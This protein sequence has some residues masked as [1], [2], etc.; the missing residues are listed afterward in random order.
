M[1]RKNHTHKYQL[2]ATG[3]QSVWACALPD[4]NHYMPPH[5][6][7]LVE[8]RT[9][10]CWQCEEKF[11]LDEESMKESRP[12]CFT[13]RDGQFIESLSPI[14]NDVIVESNDIDKKKAIEKFMKGI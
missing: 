4:C 6:S 9:S 5:L 12:R 8:G 10:I 2:R 11:I 13:C 14:I 1:P 3:S 7:S